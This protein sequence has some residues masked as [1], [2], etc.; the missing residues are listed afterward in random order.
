MKKLN[1]GILGGTGMVGQQ[2]LRLLE[3]HPW[4]NVTWFAASERSAGKTYYEAVKGRWHMQSDI[5]KAQREIIVKKITDIE[6]CKKNCS[7]VFSALDSGIAKEF[8]EKYAE[9]GIPVVSN[10]STHRHTKDVPMIIPEI[11]PEHTDIIQIQ[12]KNR[13][14]EK[15]FIAVKPNCSLHSYMTPFL[16]YTK[17]LEWKK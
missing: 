8:E 1:V 5:P 7:F 14:W 11:N 15:G 4:F 10:A 2:Y 16:H 17:N 3:N 9:A 6:D 13:G 12:Q